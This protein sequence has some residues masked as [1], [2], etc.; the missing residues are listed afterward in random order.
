MQRQTGRYIK[1]HLAGESYQAYVPHALPPKPS[2]DIA[3][4]MPALEQAL[5]HLAALNTLS[6]NIPNHA[7]FIYMYVHKEA[8]LSSQIEGTQSSF[9]DLIL[10][11]NKQKPDVCAHDVKEVSCY[12]KAIQYGIQ[13]MKAGFPLSLRLIRDIHAILLSSGRGSRMQPGTFRRSQ[14]WIGGTCPANAL[15][16]PPPVT[17]LKDC[18]SSFESFLHDASCTIL[19]RAALAHVQFETIHPFLDGNGRI[20]RMLIILLLVS[21]GVLDQPI[22]YLSLYL[23]QHRKTYYD[24]LQEV[25]THGTWETWI[26]FFLKGVKETAKQ[27][28][29]TV[30]LI[31][32]LFQEHALKIRSLKRARF[33]CEVTLEHLK[34]VPQLTV[35]QLAKMQAISQPTA[36]K[37]LHHLCDLGIIQEVGQKKRDKVYIYKSYLDIL[38][39]GT[40]PLPSSS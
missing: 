1:Q 23:K 31:Q 6:K 27:A 26:A 29:Q 39:D 3:S 22:L 36:R 18:L 24:L 30:R 16:V 25:R 20:G 19:I 34:M 2:I 5:T 15:F 28:V 32:N 38:A 35:P 9:A 4:L 10:F 21:E 7:L 14:N 17:H 8:L 37:S 11:E 40:E 12:V 33:S 13:R